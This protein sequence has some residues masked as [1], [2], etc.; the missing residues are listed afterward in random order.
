MKKHPTDLHLEALY[1]EQDSERR[2]MLLHVTGC[3]RCRERIVEILRR[4]AEGVTPDEEPDRGGREPGQAFT[5]YEALGAAGSPK[6]TALRPPLRA[7]VRI[8]GF[9]GF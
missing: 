5:L 3:A 8:Y 4:R 1:L 9:S 7:Y 6:V 2:R